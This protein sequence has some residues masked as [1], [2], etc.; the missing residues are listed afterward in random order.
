MV[1]AGPN[2]NYNVLVALFFVAVLPP[3]QTYMHSAT[4]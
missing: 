3:V 2:K 1:P 4:N